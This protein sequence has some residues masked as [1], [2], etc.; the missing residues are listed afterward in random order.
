[1]RFFY[2]IICLYLLIS[3]H[4]KPQREDSAS[5]EDIAQIVGTYLYDYHFLQRYLDDLI[6]LE[7]TDG[8]AQVLVSPAYQ[9]RVMTSTANA[10]DGRSFGWINYELIASGET[11]E[12]MNA[13]GGEDRFWLGPEGGQYAIFFPPGS[14]FNF[15]HWQTPAVIDTEPFELV[16]YT[17]QQAVFRKE[18]SL[19]NYAGTE[20]NIRI[21]RTVRMISADSVTAMLDIPVDST[22]QWVAFS[23]E[24]TITNTGPEAWEK[25][26]GLLSIWILGMFQPSSTTTVIIPYQ[27]DISENIAVVNDAYF[28]KVPEDRLVLRDG[29]IFFKGDGAYRS[30]MGVPPQRAKPVLG[31]YDA[32]NELLTIVSYTLP[33][34][35]TDYV[36]AMWEIQEEP[37]GGDAV[38]AYNDGPLE[39]G[40]Q[41]GPFYEL[42]TS[43]P[44]AALQ[45][46]E[47]L[48]HIHRTFHFQGSAGQLDPIAQKVLGVSLE[49]IG[50][51]F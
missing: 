47:K 18:T 13:F 46:N 48:T 36:N 43:S 38:N 4:S 5:Q 39:D 7:S 28:G 2:I 8:K 25:E 31:S 22:L 32:Q 42:E 9:G 51:V 33:E 40:S 41:M 10:Q 1:M 6:V 27:E 34:D 23:S 16:D 50:A 3:C 26:S 30:K 49:Q 11:Q 35:E 20:F 37:Y 29:F 19:T 17:K 12:H 44:A 14:E 45:P 21:D 24:N 15:E